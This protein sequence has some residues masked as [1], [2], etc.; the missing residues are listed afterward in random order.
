MNGPPDRPTPSAHTLAM[1]TA[2]ALLVA[3][4]VLVTIVL[5]AEYGIDPLGTGRALGLDVMT[6]RV[7]EEPVPIDPTA[8]A[9]IPISACLDPR[10]D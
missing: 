10:P 6:A 7:A 9:M 3:G 2:V 5:P 1:A 8:A 4:L